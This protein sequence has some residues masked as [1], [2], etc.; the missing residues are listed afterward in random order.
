LERVPGAIEREEEAIWNEKPGGPKTSIATLV[1]GNR[2][3]ALREFQAAR[4]LAADFKKQ[5]DAPIGREKEFKPIL[6]DKE[7][8][9]KLFPAQ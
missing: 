5:F 6:D 2:D 1:P 9:A 4:K 3:A 7:F 8:L